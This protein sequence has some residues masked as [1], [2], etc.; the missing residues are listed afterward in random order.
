MADIVTSYHDDEPIATVTID[1]PDRKNAV[2]EADMERFAETIRDIEKEDDVRCLVLTGRGD[3]FCAGADLASTLETPTAESIDRGF[4]A[5]VRSVMVSSVP[6]VAKVPGPAVGAGA[7]LAT[8][9]DFVYAAE[10]AEIGFSFAKIGLTADS[11]ATFILPRLVGR[12]QAMELLASADMIP[13]GEA[14]DMGLVTEVVPD[15]EL[16]DRVDARAVEL[17]NGPTKVLG[18]LKRLLVRSNGNTL[19][20]QLDLE[21]RE[22]ERMF[23]TDDVM[24]GM[25]AFME[26]RD[27]EFS[28]S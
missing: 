27:P 4:H 17:A 11:G 20:E 6:V 25:S 15:D 22:Q 3:A 16:D 26:G 10:S 1:N 7:S 14:A 5:G 21:S 23:N 13:A 12:L 19:E 18:S 28:G 24:E 8:A 9:C 2:S